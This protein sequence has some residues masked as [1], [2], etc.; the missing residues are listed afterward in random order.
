MTGSVE[1]FV[2][3][4]ERL[5][6]TIRRSHWNGR[7]LAGPDA[8][9]RLNAR[10]GRFVKSYLP[11]LPWSDDLVYAQAQKYWIQAN[12]LMADLQIGD[13]DLSRDT[14]VA[15]AHYLL[16]AQRPEGYWEY[17]NPEWRGRIATVEGNYAS[18]GLLETYCRT[19]ET[20]LLDAAARW[21]RYAVEHIGFQQED[22][23]LAINYFGNVPGGR[24][25]NN[26]AS[27][28]RTFAMLARA[29]NDDR[30]LA[31]G[32][33]MVRFLARYQTEGGEL[34][35]AV[36]GG[37][38]QGR[39]HFLCYQYNAFE[40]LN[41]ADYWQLT[42]DDGIW[43]VLERLAPFI[44]AGV[45]PSGA[46]RYD[47]DHDRPE[48]PY[49]TAA[50]AA[51]L[52]RATQLDIGDYRDLAERAF[53]RVLSQQRPDGGFFFS[54]GNYGMLTDRRSYPRNLAMI[55][56][57]LLA[58]VQLRSRGTERSASCGHAAREDTRQ[59]VPS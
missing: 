30:Y 50:V 1:S 28:L 32:G 21:Y 11:F 54:T 40:F 2:T 20:A 27:A 31:E 3:A 33:P 49:Y 42:R 24:V 7:A 36:P 41:L 34:P 18:I 16:E 56:S 6:A 59:P 43:P 46:A 23:T 37:I 10:A 12:W 52:S 14:A 4:A 53:A 38:G 8:G 58:E 5:A 13:P 29:S 15:T 22:G 17:P 26:S 25:P 55:L 9:I 19:G 57:H 44:A 48:V 35:Y 45:T 51:A 39:P 47:C